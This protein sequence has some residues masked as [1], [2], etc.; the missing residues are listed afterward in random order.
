MKH[1]FFPVLTIFI[2]ACSRSKD[3]LPTPKPMP[4]EM[5]QAKTWVVSGR[6]VTNGQG[7][8]AD[9][10]TG[11]P[12]CYQDDFFLF[13]AG[14]NLVFDNGAAKCSPSEHQSTT[15]T[16]V[17]NSDGSALQINFSSLTTNTVPQ[18]IRGRVEELTPAKLVFVHTDTVNGQVFAI[19]YTYRGQ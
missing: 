13:H 7:H 19:R 8:V 6:S 5:L 9:L 15:G 10:Y 17:L 18:Q 4:A 1:I 3:E 14:G 11:W 2:I 12:A 16:W